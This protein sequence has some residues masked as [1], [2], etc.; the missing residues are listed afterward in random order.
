MNVV[1]KDVIDASGQRQLCAGPK[2]GS[3]AAEH[4]IHTVFVADDTALLIDAFNDGI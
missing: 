1:K 3:E 4:A 2:A